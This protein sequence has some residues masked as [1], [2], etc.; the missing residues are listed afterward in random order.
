ME[1]I[2]T[3][4]F[5]IERIEQPEKAVLF[6]YGFSLGAESLKGIWLKNHLLRRWD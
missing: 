6:F 2:V 5:F 3:M 1:P 4:G